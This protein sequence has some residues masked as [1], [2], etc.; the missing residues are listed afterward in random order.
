M[1][2]GQPLN[3]PT[4]EEIASILFEAKTGKRLS[5]FKALR[6]AVWLY[7]GGAID[8]AQNLW[9]AEYVSHAAWVEKS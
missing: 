7:Q 3:F 1:N 8:P 4:D 9:I 2:T 6:L 5:A